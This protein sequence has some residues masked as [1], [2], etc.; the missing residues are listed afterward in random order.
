MVNQTPDEGRLS[1]ATIGREGSKNEWWA[2]IAIRKVLGRGI[3][4]ARVRE[5]PSRNTG[6]EVPVTSS[7]NQQI[8]REGPF[9]VDP[10]P[11]APESC[12]RRHLWN[13]FGSVLVRALR[14]YGFVFV[15][16]KPQTRGRNVYRLTPRGTQVHLDSPFD[17]VPACV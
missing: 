13:F 16:H 12:A 1:W 8:L 11:V 17:P 6:H 4:L 14:P 5:H 2:L 9:A 3:S 15:Q 10:L 7:S